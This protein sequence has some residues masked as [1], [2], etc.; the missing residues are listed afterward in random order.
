VVAGLFFGPLAV[1]CCTYY[2]GGFRPRRR[3]N[4]GELISP[5]RRL[6]EA[7]LA[8]ASGTAAAAALLRG[9][10]SLVQ[11]VAGA[12]DRRC[13]AAL[14]DTR[15][16]RLALGPDGARVQ[17]LLPIDSAC[18]DRSWL[19]AAHAD[20]VAAW[21]TGPDGVRLPAALPAHGTPAG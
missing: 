21:L 8:T 11:V 7:Q 14:A 2:G 17:R 19:E 5:A 10:W 18:C 6:P 1:A 13:R 9:K 15:A 3:V 4:H 12:C 20:V 16:L